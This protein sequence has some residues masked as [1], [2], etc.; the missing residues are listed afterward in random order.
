MII[1]SVV[2][3]PGSAVSR[4]FILLLAWVVVISLFWMDQS[5]T[6]QMLNSPLQDF[7]QATETDL[8][9]IRNDIGIVRIVEGH[10]IDALTMSPSF[11]GSIPLA[12]PPASL[13]R[14]SLLSKLSVYRL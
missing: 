4:C 13:P 10:A 1:S 14:A 2:S 11:S 3:P 7:Q 8:D 12:S 9:E 5:D 6:Q